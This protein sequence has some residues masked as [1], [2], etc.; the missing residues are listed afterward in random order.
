[1]RKKKDTAAAGGHMGWTS[2]YMIYDDL[3]NLRFIITPKAVER[4][5]GDWNLDNATIRKELCFQFEYDA[6]R[7][8]VAR[9]VPGGGLTEMVYDSRD[10]LVYTR[11]AN[12]IG[13]GW[14][15]NFYDGANRP[16]KTGIY[17]ANKSRVQLQQE[18]DNIDA[19]L[20]E[21]NKVYS[22]E[23]DLVVNSRDI[24]IQR[25]QAG[26]SISF[27]PD[28]D[29]GNNDMEA[30][31]VPGSSD[32]TYTETVLV[33]PRPS[34]ADID[35]ISYNY[36]DDYAWAGAQPFENAQTGKLGNT[37]DPNAD[38]AL[39]P[40]LAVRN[41]MTGSRV[42]I[43]S[44]DQWL[45][46]TV[47]YNQNGRTFQTISGNTVGGRD[48]STLLFDFNG[49]VL[50]SYFD[51]SNPS[52]DL[53]RRTAVLTTY[54]YDHEDRILEVKT[55]LNDDPN[56]ER[57]VAKNEYTPTGE[58]K[59]KTLGV[60]PDGGSMDFLNYDY[61]VRGWLTGINRE[62][63]ETDNSTLNK[64][65]EVI[66][67]D[68]GFEMPQ[69]N[70]NIA[71]IKWKGGSDRIA[72][73]Y[74]FIYDEFD[75]LKNADFNQQNTPGAAWTKDKVNYTVDNL[76]YDANGNILSMSQQGLKGIA[77][78]LIDQLS[79]AYK[80]NSNKL[81]GVT[82][83]VNDPSSL[84][85]DFKDANGT[86]A[87]DYD[88]DDAG[89]LLKD[90]NKKITS[91]S[92]NLLNKPELITVEGK[93]TI[94]Y[95]YD[96]TGVR[97]KKIVKDI[98]SGT[99]VVT[100]TDYVAGMTYKNDVL[101]FIPHIEGRIR[102]V[103]KA[104]SPI[105]YVY[106]YFE[107]DHQGNVRVVLTEQT[108]PQVYL[109]SMESAAAPVETALFS[110]VDVTRSAKPVGYPEDRLTNKN[111][112]VAKLNAKAGSQKIGP[113]LVLKVTA[114]DTV[115]ISTRAFYKSTG[116]AS[117][118]GNTPPEEM[119]AA[120]LNSFGG[121]ATAAD[122]HSAVADRTSPF[123][124]TFTDRDY[125]SLTQKDPDQPTTQ[126]RAYLNYVLFD[127]QF[128]MVD[129]NSG[130][131][132]VKSTPDE[133]QTL[134]TDKMVITQGGFLYIYSSNESQQDVYFDNMA[135]VLS[136]GPILEETHYYPF[137][138]EMA[139]ISYNASG[140]LRNN[141][142]YNGG[143][144]WENELEISQYN[145]FYRQYDPQIG[146]FLGVDIAA[147][148]ASNFSPYSFAYNNPIL[149]NDP[150]G[151]VS[152]VW[153]IIQTINAADQ[154]YGGNWNAAN[155]T[156]AFTNPLDAFMTGAGQISDMGMWGSYGVA[157]SYANAAATY[158]GLLGGGGGGRGGGGI[159]WYAPITT[160]LPGVK[161]PYQQRS[162]YPR[163]GLEIWQQINNG[164]TL[165][166]MGYVNED[167]SSGI[168]KTIGNYVSKV[169]NSP[170]ARMMIP[171]AYQIGFGMS[172]INLLGSSLSFEA[173]WLIRGPEA[174]IKPVITM[175]PSTA[176]AKAKYGGGYS[177][178]FGQV[179][180]LG[181]VE[182]ITRD[183][184]ETNIKKGGKT[185]FV[186]TGK[187]GGSYTPGDIPIITTS[188][189]IPLLEWLEGGRSAGVSNS[190]ILYK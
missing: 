188:Y 42:R 103:Y 15:V 81:E 1:M 18:I 96:A 158:N 126:P 160:M 127:N 45:T 147:E 63:V 34:E 187:F 132:Q 144:E 57:V 176:F 131:K 70:R 49:K 150:M 133:L 117:R 151:D 161:I 54:Q 152:S 115:Q 90:L 37:G 182:S 55:K 102:P 109:A 46:R 112:M 87:I 26:N 48:V 157:D 130:V 94:Q 59:K 174:S 165:P 171:D 66:Y 6:K 27:E 156:T 4:I 71:G 179:Y 13:K 14:M 79:Y 72:R 74:G 43:L 154:G 108:T 140:P 21:D 65:G 99:P 190:F 69:Y 186:N 47:Y 19:V 40:Q 78:A 178:N 91:I 35:W 172:N 5:L 106:D 33:N 67:Y 86:N 12:L 58:L 36:Y 100:T 85:G 51:H 189:S 61:N 120:L 76:Q 98:T 101:Q 136:P 173:T 134:G 93:G 80:P 25:Y 145:T 11:G 64:F 24:T 135:V 2:M 23:T 56:L 163:A 84:L 159:D 50:S 17:N 16:E 113:S 181:P 30:A 148:A 149:Y 73:A 125:R 184:M 29:S 31:I 170:A 68:Y 107:R 9:I 111:E 116:P 122:E 41:R 22:K 175:T 119:V 146:R 166:T 177:V 129:A 180:V 20:Q 137:G 164:W 52:N 60:R 139:G 89:N 105:D 123:G 169:W 141:Y 142:R 121:S 39:T 32:G 28:F 138:L 83:A 128:K 185:F 155:G 124:N 88:Y 114:G 104:G 10:R 38:I 75:Q 183:I 153:E 95:V 162:A 7:R 168:W 3:N 44:T 143:N 110:N 92:Y 82:D 167:H 118:Q 97:V 53:T 8:I 77:S 62:F